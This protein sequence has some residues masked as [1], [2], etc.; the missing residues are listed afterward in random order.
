MSKQEIIAAIRRCARELGRCPSLGE[1]MK[2]ERVAKK[3]VLKLFGSYAMAVRA[4]GM[5][6]LRGTP[7]PLEDLF[8]DWASVVRKVGKLPTMFEY[9]RES[10]YSSRPLVS[11]FKGWRN[12]PAMMLAYAERQGLEEKWKDV[13]EMIRSDQ[14]EVRAMVHAGEPRGT[15]KILRD[16]PMYGPP[17]MRTAMALGPMNE[18]G[19]VFLFGMMAWELGF[20]VLR[21]QSGFPDCV[22]LRKVDDQTWQEA[23]IEFEH[24]S[25]NFLRHG[26]PPSGCDLIVCW[27]HNWPECPV[28]VV[29]L[30]GAEWGQS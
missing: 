4:C 21:I 11:R 19:V 12:V 10:A 24:E 18:M 8:T 5:E 7:T 25:R 17:M 9:Q 28:E 1:L 22:A 2:R 27:I 30:R 15:G 3:N 29:E 26:H 20:V 6:P 13:M 16:R 14:G 23:R